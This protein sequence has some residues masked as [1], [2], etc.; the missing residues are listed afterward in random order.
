MRTTVRIDDELLR[1]AKRRSIASGRTLGAVIDDSLR[2]YFA[3]HREGNRERVR[4]PTFGGGRV[5]PGV[6][7][8]NSAALLDL[9]EP[10]NEPQALLGRVGGN[11]PDS[12][13][14]R[15]Q[16]TVWSLTRPAAC[17]KA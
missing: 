15:K 9:M 10:P 4:L 3:R 8:D 2:E 1:E 13:A 12:S 16:P 5:A 7:L 11:S 17:M 6:D 14:Y